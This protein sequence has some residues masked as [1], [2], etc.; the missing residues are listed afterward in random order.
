ME[1]FSSRSSV[2]GGDGWR[3]F[4]MSE[5]GDDALCRPELQISSRKAFCVLIAGARDRV[6]VEES[7]TK[8]NIDGF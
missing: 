5:I 6:H 4:A 3:R 8:Q 7:I 1:S 2:I